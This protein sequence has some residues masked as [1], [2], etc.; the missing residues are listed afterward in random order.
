MSGAVRVRATARHTMTR[1]LLATLC[2]AEALLLG[3]CGD[4]A[5]ERARAARPE[6]S[7]PAL[8][9]AYVPA[10]LPDED[11]V[12]GY[13]LRDRRGDTLALE[14]VVVAPDRLESV[15]WRPAERSLRRLVVQLDARGTPKQWDLSV[16]TLG[17]PGGAVPARWRVHALDEALHV[18]EGALIGV[19][20]TL[21]SLPAPPGTHPW[22]DGSGV[23]LEQVVRA[24]RRDA[25]SPVPA[26]ALPLTPRLSRLRI[27][28][29]HADTVRVQHPEGEWRLA[30]DADGHL[31]GAR[32]PSAGWELV[33][34]EAPW[35]AARR[36]SAP[37]E[38]T[39]HESAPHA[40]APST[41]GQYTAEEVVLRA[42]DG[43]ALA[44][45]F[46]RPANGAWRR[47]ALLVSG[48][49]PQDRDLAVPGLPG[50]RLFADLADALLARGVAVLRFDDRGTGRSGGSAYAAT[51]AQEADDVRRMLAW[52]ASRGATSD[53]PEAINGPDASDAPA[54]SNAPHP[55][56]DVVLVGHS[57]GGLTVL[58]AVAAPDSVAHA[59]WHAPLDL[60][61]V[62]LVGTP[63][64]S[65]RELAR[66]QRRR[67]VSR[68][69]AAFPAPQREAV[70]ARLE[71]ET[72][73]VAAV[74]AWLRAWLDDD[75]HAR[76]WSL[77]LPAL[78]VHGERD[79]QVPVAQA[80]ELAAL[81]RRRGN[82]DVALRTLPG[83]NHLLLADT[84]G[85][86]RRYRA[87]PSSRADRALL[88]TLAEW[89][90]RVPAR[91][92]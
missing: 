19:P 38:F 45:T 32:S 2:L 80:T 56:R 64:R 87:L 70:L 36:G 51:T 47:A 37:Q 92:R 23:L 6:R 90:T 33:R 34:V 35:P 76:R 46:A 49:G 14:Q 50:Y 26:A 29:V 73:A 31:L 27:A 68:D 55:T 53:A 59:P 69:S 44:G 24:W 20:L 77:D 28:R 74:D 16:E 85:D 30:L 65:G 79:E 89:L 22:I 75:P 13:V 66:T 83:V 60:A 10:V 5:V 88:D 61:G 72:E 21:R 82:R 71:R 57:D 63:S 15:T 9:G 41:A 54:T 43:V 84:V 58:D 7:L 48:A 91:I 67:F 62:L 12:H 25:A 1:A 40:S 52:L 11:G 86:P 18:T 3:A 39:P 42:S 81:L 8:P 4:A 17:E 78:L